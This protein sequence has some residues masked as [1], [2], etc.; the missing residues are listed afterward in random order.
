MVSSQH[1]DSPLFLK[2]GVLDVVLLSLEVSPFLLDKRAECH[3]GL[4]HPTVLLTLEFPL[5]L[6][7]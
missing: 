5:R 3:S 6:F 4:D 7:Y 1:I 2:Q